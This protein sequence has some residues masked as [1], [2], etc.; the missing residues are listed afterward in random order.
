MATHSSTLAWQISWTEEP[1]RLQ[2]RTRLKRLSSSSS[3]R[4]GKNSDSGGNGGIS[5]VGLGANKGP[6]L[7][8][9]MPYIR[10]EGHW[11][12]QGLGACVLAWLTMQTFN[13]R[14]NNKE[15]VFLGFPAGS[16]VKNLPAKAGDTA[17]I[18]DLGR[19]QMLKSN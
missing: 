19:S 13:K 18:P 17:S 15:M 16:V 1:G 12:T 8:S 6:G 9:R 10:A 4:L 7:T 2:S 3:S 11:V 5:M 14:W